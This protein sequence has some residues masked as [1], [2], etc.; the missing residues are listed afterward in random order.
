MCCV[1]Y[2]CVC[3]CVCLCV[4][5]VCV[6][7]CIICV[8]VCACLSVCTC[9]YL[10]MHVCVHI[11]MCVSVCMDIICVYVSMYVCVYLCVCV[12]VA[13]HSL[14]AACSPGTPRLLLAA[15]GEVAG[16]IGTRLGKTVLMWFQNLT[17]NLKLGRFPTA[18]KKLE[19]LQ[20]RAFQDF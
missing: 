19:I 4:R 17:N 20:E 5:V 10:C 2:L 7:V 13:R 1:Y 12:C 16:A 18:R 8:S 11:C 6:S 9:V 3:T 15:D 14:W